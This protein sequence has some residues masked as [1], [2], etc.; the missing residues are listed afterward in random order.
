MS[1]YYPRIIFSLVLFT[2]E[3]TEAQRGKALST[4][5]IAGLKGEGS[6]V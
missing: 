4:P 2:N 5:H 6:K 3:E 1:N